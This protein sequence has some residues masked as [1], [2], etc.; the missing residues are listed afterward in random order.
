MGDA[1]SIRPGVGPPTE[2]EEGSGCSATIAFGGLLGGDGVPAGLHFP[3]QFGHL[4]KHGR[5][6]A[7]IGL[8]Q[9]PA[10]VFVQGVQVCSHLAT[11]LN[12]SPAKA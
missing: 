8:G 9:A 12:Q 4:V 3:Q 7:Q 2:G 11:L 5:V 1:P 6:V 10:H